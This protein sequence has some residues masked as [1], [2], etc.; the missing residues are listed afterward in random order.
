MIEQD[1]IMRM[2]SMLTAAIV[3]LIDQRK[4]KEFPEA[5]TTVDTACR[6]LLGA[7]SAVLAALSD[8]QLI[9]FYRRDPNTGPVRWYALGVLLQEKGRILGE[10]GREAEV[11]AIEEKS[12]SLLLEALREME[13]PLE[14]DH[15]DRVEELIRRLESVELAPHILPK[16]A[17]YYEWRGRSQEAVA[18]H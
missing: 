14:A 8:V 18:P 11:P 7:D 4:R 10:L 2:I 1:Y 9:E 13:K 5:L 15:C 16:V 3:K 12:L 17:W 6:H